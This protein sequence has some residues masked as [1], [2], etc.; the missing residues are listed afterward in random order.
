MAGRFDL[1][2]CAAADRGAERDQ[3]L[4]EDR[5]RVGL[6]IRRDP[7]D[8]LAEQLVI[9]RRRRGCR[10][11]RWRRQQF[12]AGM[13]IIARRRVK[14]RQSAHSA[15]ISATAARA[16][17]SSTIAFFA[18]NAAISEDTARLFT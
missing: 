3:Q 8:D 16:A 4:G 18:A 9:D 2:P 6:R 15:E 14:Q 11:S 12:A 5:D 10:P 13:L 17:D 7:A 1:E